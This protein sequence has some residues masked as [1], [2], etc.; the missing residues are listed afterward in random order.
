MRDQQERF[1]RKKLPPA[2]FQR[3]LLVAAGFWIA[4]F[5][6]WLLPENSPG[7]VVTFVL[8]G[9]LVLLGWIGIAV[10]LLRAP[11]DKHQE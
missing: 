4:F 6:A 5:G 7:V 11:R 9:G 10:E 3:A 1:D 8:G 2:L